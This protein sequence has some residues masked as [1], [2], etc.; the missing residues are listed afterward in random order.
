MAK[1]D[2]FLKDA[3]PNYLPHESELSHELQGISVSKSYPSKEIAHCS[4]F[5][6]LERLEAFKGPTLHL[7]CILPKQASYSLWDASTFLKDILN[8]F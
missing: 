3:V 7:P 2:L 4:S 6:D 8:F 1:L 5:L